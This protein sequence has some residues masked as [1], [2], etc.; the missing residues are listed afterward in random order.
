MGSMGGHGRPWE[1][2]GVHGSPW[3]SMGVHAIP[4]DHFFDDQTPQQD[5]QTQCKRAGQA[6]LHPPVADQL[7]TAVTARGGRGQFK[8]PAGYKVATLKVSL[9]VLRVDMLCAV[10]M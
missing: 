3:E 4:L 8:C 1:A 7:T 2:M 10:Y 6:M 9:C 5:A